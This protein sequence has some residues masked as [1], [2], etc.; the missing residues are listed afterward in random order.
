MRRGPGRRRGGLVRLP[1]VALLLVA[2]AAAPRAETVSACQRVALVDA[3]DGAAVVGA[4]DLAL[5]AEAGRLYLSAFDRWALEDALAEKAESLPQGAIYATALSDLA[6]RPETLS[7]KPVATGSGADFHPHGIDLYRGAEGAYLFAVN[8]RHVREDGAWTRRTRLERFRI[9]EHGLAPAGGT[10][11][12]RLCQANDVAALSAEDALVTRDHGRCSSLGRLLED[13]LGLRDAEVVLV[14]LPGL[15]GVGAPP[16]R[17][18]TSLASDL[19]FANG[20]ALAPD[21]RRLAVSATRQKHI[22]LYAA[23]A[24][25]N[26][27]RQVAPREIRVDGGPDNLS[28]DREGRVLTALHP[29]LLEVGL[30]HGRWFGWRR[31]GTRVIA[32]DPATG[33]TDLL[34]DDPEGTRLNTGTA[35]VATGPWLI[36]S[37]V[38]DDALLICRR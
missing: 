29:S 21:G 10:G 37:S 17:T 30:A 3:R 32:L 35:A 33:A 22:R 34:L 5:D 25:L 18:I 9:A 27:A 28:W 24:L 7:L 31:A 20:L 36:V 1:T 13:V 19:G 12:P 14:A 4:E 16:G 2:L 15:S 26:P 6:E 23:P 38:L 11:D 8:H